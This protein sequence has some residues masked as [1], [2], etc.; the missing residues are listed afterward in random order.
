LGDE[1][2]FGLEVEFGFIFQNLKL[3]TWHLEVSLRT[4]FKINP[5]FKIEQH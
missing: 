2:G 1:F 4:T 3:M 5:K